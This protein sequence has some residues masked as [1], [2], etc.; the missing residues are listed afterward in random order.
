MIRHYFTCANTSKGFVNYFESNLDGMDKIYILK[1]G[2]GT[3][4]STLM[5]RIGTIFSS[6]YDVDFIHCSSDVESLDG[7]VIRELKVA[8]VDGTA[9]HV[10]EPKAPGAIEEYVH[11]GTAWNIPMLTEGKEAIVE[12]Q[13]NIKE[14]YRLAYEAFAKAL[15]V[16][17]DWEKVY[18]A[19]MDFDKANA[20]TDKLT[21]WIVGPTVKKDVKGREWHRFFGAST[22]HG[23]V[24]FIDNLTENL[25]TR[26]FIKGRPGTG[27]STM[28]KKIAKSAL[29][30]GFDVEVYHCAFAPDSL[31]MLIIPERDLCIFDSTAPHEHFANQDG[32]IYVDVYAEFIAEGTDELYEE[33]LKDTENAYRE[34]INEACAQLGKAKCYH[35]DLEKYY[36]RATD[37]NEINRIKKDLLN[38]IQKRQLDSQNT[39]IPLK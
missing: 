1:G 6:S 11:L 31:D 25:S 7:V 34:I 3:G 26:Y 17:D 9:P 24:D 15:T 33:Q 22:P 5:K 10:I 23:S 29:D 16:H 12:L 37:F 4:K 19:H 20:L 38:K 2:P 28:L 18:I 13:A 8:V 36:I 27:K 35:D 32:D 21:E 30:A 14:C 39:I